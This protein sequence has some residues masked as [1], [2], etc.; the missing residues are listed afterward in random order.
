VLL[1][2]AV[3]CSVVQCGAVCCS[4]LQCVAVCCSVLLLGF[5]Y[6]DTAPE[7]KIFR[8][9][10]THSNTLQP[11][12]HLVAFERRCCAHSNRDLQVDAES[13]TIKE[14]C[15]CVCVCIYVHA[16]VC[17]CERERERMCVC[18]CVYVYVYVTV[19]V[20]CRLIENIE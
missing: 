13:K 11:G 6:C 10:A 3:W 15:I 19:T 2:V 12:A 14:N 7:K 4:V 1:C 16:C 5:K 20:T 8:H 17:V 18:V 9:I